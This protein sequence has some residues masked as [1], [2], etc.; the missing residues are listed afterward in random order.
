[1]RNLLLFILFL[2]FLEVNSHKV[3]VGSLH[4]QPTDLSAS[5]NKVLDLNG[6]PCALLKI[7]VV[8]DLERIE[9]NVIG[10]IISKDSE[11]NVYLSGG[12]KELRIFPKGKLP[13]HVVF[14]DYG[15]D[16]LEQE[17]TY[18]LRLTSDSPTTITKEETNNDIPIFEFYAEDLVTMC[19]GQIPINNLNLGGNTD[20]LFETLKATGLNPT[21]ETYG[22][23]VFYTEDPSKCKGFN[24]IKRKFKL[25]GCD[26]MPEDVSMGFEPDKYSEGRITY[27]F[28]FYHGNKPDKRE[29]AREQSGIFVKALY[30][31]LEKAGYKLEGT[32]KSAKG[33]TDWGEITLVYNDNYGECWI[34][35]Y[36]NNYFKDKK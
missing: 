21:K 35:L 29:N 36:V 23:G 31:E 14:K 20:T 16:A 34:G 6:N 25:K 10:K 5:V 13:I 1:M 7:W 3:Q 26:V 18:I 27:Q 24:A 9:G 4:L 17:R 15:I 28:K 22:I 33:Q 8:D 32:Y 12:S 11:K 19:F 30:S 2:P